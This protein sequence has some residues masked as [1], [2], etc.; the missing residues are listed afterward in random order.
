M[1]DSTLSYGLPPNLAGVIDNVVK[2]RCSSFERARAQ[3]L[4]G[5]EKT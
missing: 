4:K 3:F 5:L 2:I 1:L